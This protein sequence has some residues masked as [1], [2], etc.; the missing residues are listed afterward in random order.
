MGEECF[1][2]GGASV[3]GVTILVKG[4]LARDPADVGLLG[5]LGIVSEGGGIT[6]SI[7]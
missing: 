2:V 7:Q 6:D 3:L 4:D 5:A 1:D